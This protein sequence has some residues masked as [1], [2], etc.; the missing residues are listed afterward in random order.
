MDS[1]HGIRYERGN[2]IN[3][4]SEENLGV[5]VIGRVG[6]DIEAIAAVIV[7][8]GWDDLFH[9]GKV[10]SLEESGNKFSNIVF[11]ARN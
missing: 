7:G 11:I 1:T 8:S 6:I 5:R 9:N 4:A 10:V 3:V 2:R